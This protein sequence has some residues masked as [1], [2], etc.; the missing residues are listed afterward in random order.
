[1]G[2]LS[3]DVLGYQPDFITSKELFSYIIM[4][5]IICLDVLSPSNFLNQY[6]KVGPVNTHT[7][8]CIK[9]YINKITD[10]RCIKP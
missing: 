6:I 9:N 5:L 4:M 1:M 7:F 2:F 10:V 8:I 3:F